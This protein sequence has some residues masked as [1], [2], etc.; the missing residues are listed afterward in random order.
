M[1][2]QPDGNILIN[3]LINE[4]NYQFYQ[5]VRLTAANPTAVTQIGGNPDFSV[6]PNP[7]S[8]EVHFELAMPALGTISLKD[9][10]GKLV[11]EQPTGKGS[12]Q[13]LNISTLAAGIYVITYQDNQTL[14]SKKLIKE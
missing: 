5:V 11:I 14:V 4:E 6:Y 3:G 1:V 8:T 12:V 9:M 2:L 7:A 13:S 10:T